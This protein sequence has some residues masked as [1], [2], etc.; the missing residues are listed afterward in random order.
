[1]LKSREPIKFRGHLSGVYQE[2]PA[3]LICTGTFH[4]LKIFEKYT[5]KTYTFSPSPKN[6][7]ITLFKSSNAYKNHPT[8]PTQ[9]FLKNKYTYE[10]FSLI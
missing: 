1:M 6:P 4:I 3:Q 5:H 7:K 10:T 8:N 9:T 2:K